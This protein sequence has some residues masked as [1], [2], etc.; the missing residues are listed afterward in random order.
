MDKLL[1]FLIVLVNSTLKI[2]S[3]SDKGLDKTLSSNHRLM[4]QF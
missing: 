4:C 2:G 1:Y 3:H